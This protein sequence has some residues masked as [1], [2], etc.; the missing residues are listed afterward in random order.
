MLYED[1]KDISRWTNG[2]WD[3]NLSPL[4]D[5]IISFSLDKEIQY[6]AGEK[7]FNNFLRDK[8]IVYNYYHWDENEKNNIHEKYINKQINYTLN[9][10]GYR[11]PSFFSD[12]KLKIVT[13]GCSQTFGLGIDDQDTWANQL[14]NLITSEFQ[15]DNV[16]VFN[17]GTPSASSERNLIQLYQLIDIINP[18]VVLWMPS[19]MSR[20]SIGNYSYESVDSLD[21]C[22]ITFNRKIYEHGI[23]DILRSSLNSHSPKDTKFFRNMVKYRML[24][25]HTQ[26]TDHCRNLAMIR[27][28]CKHRNIIFYSFINYVFT[29]LMF[30][31]LLYSAINQKPVQLTLY[32]VKNLNMDDKLSIKLRI[33]NNYNYLGRLQYNKDITSND[34]NDLLENLNLYFLNKNQKN[35]IK[36]ETIIEIVSSLDIMTKIHEKFYYLKNDDVNTPDWLKAR[37]GI[38]SGEPFHYFLSLISFELLKEDIAKLLNTT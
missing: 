3:P 8:H 5:H 14:K 31:E 22:D 11:S 34:G 7:I 27:D 17:L 32:N 30:V 13:I 18:N 15:T 25:L 35:I 6:E 23:E 1:L 26:Y 28:L 33:K 24:D 37:D 36:F 4:I 21:P 29:H 2:I 19:H 16:E 38:H 12:K 9:A 20:F 10:H